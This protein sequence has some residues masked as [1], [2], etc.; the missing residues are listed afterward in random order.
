[1]VQVR[2]KPMARLIRAMLTLTT[3][4]PADLTLVMMDY[5]HMMV[6]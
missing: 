2:L 3:T 1:M 6:I 5:L 4:H